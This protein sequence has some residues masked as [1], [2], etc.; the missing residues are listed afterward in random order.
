MGDSVTGTNKHYQGCSTGEII[1]IQ[2]YLFD[3]DLGMTEE[4]PC[5]ELEV[6]RAMVLKLF[7]TVWSKACSPV[8]TS[9]LTPPRPPTPA[10][11]VLKT[12]DKDKIQKEKNVR[13]QDRNLKK[14]EKTKVNVKKDSGKECL[15]FKI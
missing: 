6:D 15:D 9:S 10:H 13:K 14:E 8:F 4:Q 12:K 1:D 3:P 11:A 5:W 2:K 7:A